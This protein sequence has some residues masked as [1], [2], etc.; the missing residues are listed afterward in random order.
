MPF[1]RGY[2]RKR[3]AGRRRYRGK[4]R[5]RGRRAPGPTK[6]ISVSSPIPDQYFAKLKYSDQ[7]FLTSTAGI[8]SHLFRA[9]SINDPNY[10]GIG[11]QPFGYDQLAE[12]YGKQKVYGCKYRFTFQNI[13]TT[14]GC[15]VAIV[16]KNVTNLSTDMNTV[17][18]KPYTQY[19][20]L[21]PLNSSFNYC[22][23]KGYH[24][25]PKVR[26]VSKEKYRDEDDYSSDVHVDLATAYTNFMHI[27]QKEQNSTTGIIVA[28]HVDLVYFVKFFKRKALT[29]S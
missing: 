17:R 20:S 29:G 22:V 18:E 24:S 14:H 27:Y 10:T 19:R 7:F 9:N 15:D 13:S 5:F 3:P 11:H 12:L 4:R 28:V 16:Q 25:A 2:K 6:V 23:L 1:R 8:T 26:G 21:G